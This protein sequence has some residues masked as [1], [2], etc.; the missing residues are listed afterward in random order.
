MWI[1]YTLAGLAIFG[2]GA[3]AGIY[4]VTRNMFR[5]W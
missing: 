2:L 3:V 4:W 1:V 5:N